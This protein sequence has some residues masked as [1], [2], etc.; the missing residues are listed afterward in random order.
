MCTYDTLLTGT[1]IG[2]GALAVRIETVQVEP[3]EDFPL[4][5]ICPSGHLLDFFLYG[6]TALYGPGPPRFVRFHGHSH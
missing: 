3:P 4:T 6:S 1:L 2:Y 5:Q